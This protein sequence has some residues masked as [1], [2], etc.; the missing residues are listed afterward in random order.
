[1]NILGFLGAGVVALGLGWWLMT[2]VRAER[3]W[4][5]R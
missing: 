1:L 5:D 2:N 4:P 3:A